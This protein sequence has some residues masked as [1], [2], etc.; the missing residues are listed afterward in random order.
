LYDA[1]V[2]GSQIL[3]AGWNQY[4]TSVIGYDT[5]FGHEGDVF[6]SSR[7]DHTS[8]NYPA[9]DGVTPNGQNS[10]YDW[11]DPDN[12][13]FI[14]C[15]NNGLALNAREFPGGPFDFIDMGEGFFESNFP[16]LPV[17]Q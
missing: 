9:L 7:Y 10:F 5:W 16:N 11:Y 2:R 6:D 1:Y 14:E 15:I 17:C 13:F 8:G 12:Y 3:S 4:N